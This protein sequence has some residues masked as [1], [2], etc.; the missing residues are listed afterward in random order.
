MTTDAAAVSMPTGARQA[1]EVAD[2]LGV[3]FGGRLSR[4][5]IY[6][7]VCTSQQALIAA[8]RTPTSDLVELVARTA[9]EQRLGR[10]VRATAADNQPPMMLAA[11][12]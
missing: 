10:H 3:A 12:S 7:C 11:A 6:R 9:I 1:I 5:A 4:T 8:G 2:R